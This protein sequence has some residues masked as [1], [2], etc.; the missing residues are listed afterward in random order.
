MSALPELPNPLTAGRIVGSD[1]DAA[2]YR[3][4]VVE[5]GHKDYIMGRTDL[6][7]FARCP[8]KW[9]MGYES[10][11][12]DAT[13][14]GQ[15]FEQLV[16]YPEAAEFRFA[17]C[18]ETYPDSKTGEPKPW[19]FA[20]NFCKEWKK[21]QG[22]KIIVKA[23]TWTQAQNATKFFWARPQL[24]NLVN[25]SKK[26]VMVEAAYGD[27]ETGIVV[28]VR[29][30]LDFVPDKA[31]EEF[32]QCL[33]DLKTTRNAEP[34]S[35]ARDVFQ[36]GLHVQGALYLD[37]YNCAMKN[38]SRIDF[39]HLISESGPPWEPAARILSQDFITLGRMRYIDAL[40]RYCACLKS[41]IWPGYDTAEAGMFYKGWLITEAESWMINRT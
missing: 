6:L 40:K 28:H 1:I 39:R 16:M 4:Q 34:F 8:H 10:E 41:G 24:A 15:L 9:L 3:H 27:K 31:S 19:T 25:C 26:Q 7:D 30:L 23:E 38:E 35:W 12:T 14:W 22:K 37:L 29:G 18:P 32:G 33:A 5:R 21:E 2:E 36:Y 17:V 11:E 20:A 13:E